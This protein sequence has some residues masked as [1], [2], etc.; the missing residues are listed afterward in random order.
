MSAACPVC[1][2]RTADFG[3]VLVR[4]CHK[5]SYRRCRDCGS[6][7]VAE[8]TWLDEAY[9]EPLAASDVGLVDRN[10]RLA[11]LTARYLIGQ[12]LRRGSFLDVGGGSGLFVRLM[13]DRGFDFRYFDEHSTNLFAR[14]VEVLEIGGAY[15]VV[16]AFEVLE[17][18]V[19]PHVLL[20]SV[21]KVSDSVLTSTMLLP[22]P[23]P[24]P[25]EWWYYATE[26]GQHVTLY[27]ARGLEALANV[28]G[29]RRI[30]VGD[31]HLFTGAHGSD[32]YRRFLLRLPR[33]M[34]LMRASKRSLMLADHARARRILPYPA[35]QASEEKIRWR[36]KR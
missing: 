15:D 9:A 24:Q 26:T 8:P 18:L 30:S 11:A 19:D 33:W 12:R 16:T 17:H 5:A 3:T 21:A 35:D 1:H 13:R 28:L 10:L 29:F 7:H 36:P 34:F 4:G 27:T 14:D 32:H 31:V 25:S 20:S 22:E 6:V 23:A 2:G